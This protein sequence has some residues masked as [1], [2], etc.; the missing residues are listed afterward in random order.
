MLEETK[1]Y[2]N[3]LTIGYIFALSMIAVLSMSA[4]VI[5][6]KVITVQSSAATIINISGRQRMLSQRIGM[7]SC[8]YSINPN[9]YNKESLVKAIALMEKSHLALT[10]GDKTLGL[11]S[12]IPP[13]VSEI[14]YGKK[15]NLDHEVKAYIALSKQFVSQP[16]NKDVLLRIM[17]KS[18]DSLLNGLDKV[19]KEYEA[20]SIEQV[21]MI[22]LTQRIVLIIIIATLLAEALFIFRPIIQKVKH[23]ALMLYELAT[24]DFLTKFANRRLI[25]EIL[26]KYIKRAQIDKKSISIMMI[27]IDHF[28]R[29]NDTYGHKVGDAVIVSI[30]KTIS[31]SVRPSDVCS[32]WG[33]E[34]FLIL[35]SDT[36]FND[37]YIVAQRILSSIENEII[38][39]DNLQISATVSIG[40]SDY[41]DL[42]SISDFIERA[43]M[44]LYKA[45]E[46]GRNR[47]EK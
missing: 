8:H 20:Q 1:K 35:L 2:L 21:H 39:I 43:D 15:Y 34:E 26:E 42:E 3:S 27:D 36:N 6:D 24:H 9:N 12:T 25:L 18:H 28:K 11:P 31:K 30:A 23:F 47:I 33:G 32:R 16:Q 17:D 37:A 29:I 46:N 10:K 44:A 40:L 38:T 7:L 22:T 41:N 45:K 14:Y 19:V 4:H 13:K 5:L